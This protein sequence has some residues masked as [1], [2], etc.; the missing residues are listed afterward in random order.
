ME[1]ESS[2]FRLVFSPL[3]R[4]S[5]FLIF[6][7]PSVQK[8]EPKKTRKNKKI[9][10]FYNSTIFWFQK[11]RTQIPPTYFLTPILVENEPCS[12]PSEKVTSH[13]KHIAVSWQLAHYS[14]LLEL[15][16]LIIAGFNLKLG[17]CPAPLPLCRGAAVHSGLKLAKRS[18]GSPV[19]PPFMEC[20][21]PEKE[22]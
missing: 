13:T 19:Q 1:P 5:K 16:D 9:S 21:Q 8:R 3:S 14:I 11:C 10:N 15:P 18:L 20:Q 2:L 12:P 6:F 4:Q 7:H 17:E 22:I